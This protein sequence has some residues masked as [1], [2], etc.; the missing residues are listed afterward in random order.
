MTGLG[1]AKARGKQAGAE[2][3]IVV[4]NQSYLH[5]TDHWRRTTAESRRR[6]VCLSQPRNSSCRH[7]AVLSVVITQLYG[8]CMAAIGAAGGTGYDSAQ[9]G[10]K[11][12]QP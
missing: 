8:L 7:Q 5:D 2:T 6:C 3:G 11:S 10:Q 4:A 9:A 1:K 12:R